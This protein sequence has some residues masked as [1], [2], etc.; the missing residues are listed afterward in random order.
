MKLVFPVTVER[1]GVTY[2]LSFRDIPEA[3]GQTTDA[4][5]IEEEA[6][7]TAQIALSYYAKEGKAIPQPSAA[8]PGEQLIVI[9]VT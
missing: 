8:L 2:V 5:S 7:E 1:D 4:A 9:D 6:R 3:L